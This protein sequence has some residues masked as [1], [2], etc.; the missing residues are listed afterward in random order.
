MEQLLAHLVGDFT[1]QTYKM[2]TRKSGSWAWAAFHALV[3]GLPFL[4]LV[5][6]PWQWLFIV[7]THAMVDR[8]RLVVPW[9][10]FTGSGFAHSMGRPIPDAQVPPWLGGW[11]LVLQDNTLHLLLNYV[12][13]RWLP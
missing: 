7:G 5:R 8:Y 2:A 10:R 13:L 11:L 6:S 3:Y 4:L 9:C 12:A 1:L